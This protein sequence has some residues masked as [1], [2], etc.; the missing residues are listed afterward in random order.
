MTGDESK[1]QATEEQSQPADWVIPDEGVCEAYADWYHVNWLP[2]TVRIR[3]AQIVADPRTAPDKA[4]SWVLDERV[5]LTM[6]WFTVKTLS[7]MLSNLVAAYEKK[8]GEIVV[9]NM[10]DLP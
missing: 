7:N 8:N 9:P 1:S 3:F 6:P 4:S 2:L 5:A 10:P